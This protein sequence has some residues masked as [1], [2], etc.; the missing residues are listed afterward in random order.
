MKTL[1]GF[2]FLTVFSLVLIGCS[3]EKQSEEKQGNQIET[4]YVTEASFTDLEGNAVEISD[5]E[6]KVIM[7]DFWETWCKPCLASFPTM[8]K[9]LEDY[10]DDFVIL[11]VTP[12]F[13][14]TEEDAQRFV[15][16]HDYDFTFLMDTNKV[17][18]KLGVQG[19]PFKVYLDAD[20]N[21]IKN[22]MGTS[23][24]S[25]QQYDELASII[26]EHKEAS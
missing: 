17:H 15:N 10:P 25:Q 7:I 12:G 13:A 1:Q 24:D 5:F 11:A 6:G 26:E 3:E 21:F 18:E 16:E 22:S 19:I 20:G 2:I 8:Q 14:D 4:E 23:G 9:V